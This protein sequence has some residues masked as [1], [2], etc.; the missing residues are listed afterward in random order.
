VAVVFASFNAKLRI[1]IAAATGGPA[2]TERM[3]HRPG[4]QRIGGLPQMAI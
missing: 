1:T 2:R 4:R 3:L